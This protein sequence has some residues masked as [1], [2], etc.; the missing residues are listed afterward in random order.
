M[1]KSVSPEEFDNVTRG[2]ATFE[3]FF[4]VTLDKTAESE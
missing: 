4:P 2:W 3:D 1:T